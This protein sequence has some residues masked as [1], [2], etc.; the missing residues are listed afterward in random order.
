MSSPGL[1]SRG[2]QP[3]GFLCIASHDRC[4]GDARCVPAANQPLVA[5]TAVFGLERGKRVRGRPHTH[6]RARSSSRLV[7]G[8]RRP[9]TWTI[10]RH[11]SAQAGRTRP[12]A[13]DRSRLASRISRLGSCKHRIHRPSPSADPSA[14]RPAVIDGR[15][16]SSA[17]RSRRPRTEQAGYCPGGWLGTNVDRAGG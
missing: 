14:G 12:S 2:G 9:A 13:A 16:H 8:P 7:L 3:S 15:T 11:R 17:D 1:K 10:E 4:E 5:R 6:V